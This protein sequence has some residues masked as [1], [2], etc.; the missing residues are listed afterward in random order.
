MQNPSQK[1]T[2]KT[3]TMSIIFDIM[4]EI[5]LFQSIGVRFDTAER[6]PKKSEQTREAILASALEFFWSR[7]FRDLTVAELMANTG[8]SR[9]TFYQYFT[10]LY[11]LM[12]ALLDEIRADI[13]MVASPWFEEE[14]DPVPLL[15]TSLSGLVDVV[16]ESGPILRA[17]TDAA[18]SD[19]NLEETWA[20]FIGS[21]DVAVAARIEQQQ[22]M[23]LIA[24]FHAFPVAKALNRLDACLLIEHFG[25]RPRGDRK[26]VL[27]AITRIW[28]ST[29]YGVSGD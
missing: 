21:F 22:A 19:A 12:S 15:K 27:Q 5:S 2:L 24:P 26:E 18:V 25:R 8:A 29:L 7:P 3:D 28:C 14:G 16:Y 10:D 13:L 17:V 4:S 9:P 1:G 6:R 23:G 11:A 20:S